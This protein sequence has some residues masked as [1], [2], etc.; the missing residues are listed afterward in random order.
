MTTDLPTCCVC[1]ETATTLD[2]EYDEYYCDNH[3]RS[4]G[5]FD[6]PHRPVE[7]KDG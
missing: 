1:G 7:P 3:A 5:V 6:A 2:T 4:Y